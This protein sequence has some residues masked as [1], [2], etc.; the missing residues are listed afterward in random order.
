MPKL[1]F[2]KQE[3]TARI[4]KVRR[5]M[6]ARGLEA[7]FLQDPSNMCWLSGYDNWSFYTHQGLLLTMKGEPVWWGRNQD[8]EGAR[9]C[10]WLSHDNIHGYKDEYVQSSHQHPMEDLVELLNACGLERARIRLEL[11]NYYF[12]AKAYLVMRQLLRDAEFLDAT[13]LVNRQRTV[14]SPAELVLMRQAAKIS[15]KMVEGIFSRARVGMRKNALVAHIYYDGIMGTDHVGGDYPAIVPLLPSGSD[16]AAPHITWDD[17]P[18]ENNCA[19]F[20][21]ISGV[22]KRYHA[23][24]CRTIHFGEP[25]SILRRAEAA[26]VEGLENGLQAARA[27]N[28]AGDIARALA[29]PLRK[30]GIERGARCGYP[31]GLSF[32]P[33]WGERTISLRESDETVLE[34]GMTFHFMPGLWQK[35]WGMEIT[36]TILINESGAAS[37]LADMP[38]E[39]HVID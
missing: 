21:E 33:D 36:E 37:P 25:P 29:E 7:I 8:A 28:V 10:T 18:L 5:E 1:V 4:A 6:E 34:P 23:P 13:G 27:G 12:S 24:L 14:K 22:V 31:I 9:R 16:A 26:L 11:D 39:L 32:P 17:A 19:T 15:E 2:E 30:S 3:Y 38:R 35:D 20:F